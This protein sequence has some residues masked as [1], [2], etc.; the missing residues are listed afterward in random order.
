LVRR[1]VAALIGVVVLL[2]LFFGVRACNTSRHKTALKEYNR[3]VSDLGTQSRNTGTEFFK[4]M[5]QAG[6]Q[7]PQE[8]YQQI[9]SFSNE[10]D[11][12]VDQADKLNVPDDMQAAQQSLLIA[13]QFRRDGLTKIAERIR[14]ALGDEG[15]AVDKAVADIAGQ[16]RAF[17]ASDVLYQARVRP[18]VRQALDDA[19]VGGQTIA[20][21]Q[22][23]PEISWLA[24]QFVAQ[25]LGQQLSTTGESG[26]R[27]EPTGPGLHG[28]GLDATSYGNVTLQPGASN[29]LTYVA[30]QPFTVAFTNQGDNDEFNV[31]V[32][33]TIARDS[34]QPL[35]LEKTVP[36]VAKGE[37]ATVTLPLNRT[38]PLDTVVTINVVV[39][40]VP[41]EKKT[42]NNKS[43]Y[44]SLFVRG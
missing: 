20:P 30:G 10:A 27:N 23:L 26:D 6:S 24:P 17:D 4:L 2:I 9:L 34:G 13:F 36:K 43:S 21:S 11:N 37:K 19:E 38:P 5:D 39:A 15:E 7:P 29:R 14:P 12:A 25:K 3:Q 16:M 18:F 8:L 42:D 35:K 41:G 33:L 22:F 31:K 1:T 40:A 32:T 28:T 44:P